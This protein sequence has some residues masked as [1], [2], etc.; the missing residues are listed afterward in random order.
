MSRI[1]SFSSSRATLARRSM[2]T[3]AAASYL[4]TALVIVNRPSRSP[5]GQ[6]LLP[7]R[8]LNGK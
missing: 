3:T 2:A 1:R 4:S 8:F 7:F 5:D 6:G